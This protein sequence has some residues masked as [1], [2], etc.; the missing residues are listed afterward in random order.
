[1][2]NSGM[3]VWR[4]NSIIFAMEVYYDKPKVNPLVYCAQVR[5]YWSMGDKLVYGFDAGME[6]IME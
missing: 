4:K 2:H 1:M 6:L 5:E 3:S